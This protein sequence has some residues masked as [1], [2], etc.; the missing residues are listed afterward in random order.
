MKHQPSPAWRLSDA[1]GMTILDVVVVTAII[2][3][4][5][6]IAVPHVLRSLDRLRL[7]MATRDVQSELQRARLKAVSSNTFMRVRFDCPGA[8][9]YRVVERIGNPNVADAGD[10]VNARAS[11]RCNE[12][13]YPPRTGT[14][15]TNRLVRPNNDQPMRYLQEGVTFSATAGLTSTASKVIEFWPDGSA[16]VSGGPPWPVV[17]AAGV[18]ITLVRGSETRTITVTSLG[19]IQMQ[20]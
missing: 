15:G 19:N 2:G 10:D 12:T 1:R 4:A 14:A 16:H 6:A 7:G 5:S 11:T 17:S 13:Q 20:R 3:I 18:Q 9:Q 8:M